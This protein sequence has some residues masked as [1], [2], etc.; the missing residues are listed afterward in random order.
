MNLAEGVRLLDRAW[1]L[2][3]DMILYIKESSYAQIDHLQK[4]L[5]VIMIQPCTIVSTVFEEINPLIQNIVHHQL[6]EE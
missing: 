4:P 5:A 6:A 1:V 3:R 2:I